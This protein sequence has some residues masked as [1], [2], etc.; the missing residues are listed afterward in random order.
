MLFRSGYE[1]THEPLT[2]ARRNL[3][4]EL[5]RFERFRSRFTIDVVS[6]YYD[7]VVA[8]R[9]VRNAEANLERFAFLR[10]R[11]EAL[12]DADKAT[13]L[14]IFRSRQ[15]ELTAQNNLIREKQSVANALD[16]FK[17]QLGIPTAADLD[18]TIVEPP[19]RPVDVNAESAV[20]VA[21]ANRLDLRIAVDEV[22]DAE[23]KARI[24]KQF[25]LPEL[26]LDVDH[27][28]S[29]LPGANV[30]HLRNDEGRT[31][32]GASLDLPLDKTPERNAWQRSKITVQRARRTLEERRDEIRNEVLRFLRDLNTAANTVT[33]QQQAR[34]IAKKRL[35]N[36][37]ILFEIGSGP[38]RDVVEA[39]QA[40]LNAQNAYIRALADYEV[41]R[42]QLLRSL[43]LLFIRPDGMWVEDVREL[44]GG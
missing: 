24:A 42:L 31:R 37:R 15:E 7:L 8:K 14:D 21:L 2:Q 19:F 32:V 17:L 13:A 9:R 22:A 26:T 30:G 4:Y 10:K 1:A 18:V 27:D 44:V 25:L 3:V 6:S 20:K 34:E 41:S 39:Q 36:A 35:E 43:D 11:S 40:L 29:S 16:R 5:R 23:R 38:N 28:L 33:I 12:F